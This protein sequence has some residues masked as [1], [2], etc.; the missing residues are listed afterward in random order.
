MNL[1]IGAYFF[2]IA[3]VLAHLEIQI[4]GPHGWAEKLPTWRWDSPA[5]RRWFGKPVT[6]Y[7]LCLVTCILLFLHVPQF[8]GGSWER[9]ADLL[10]M[11][12]LLTVTWDFLWFAC[13]RHF[14]VARFRKGQVW[15][16]PTWA[17]GVPREYFVGIALSFG[18]ALAPA[19]STGAWADRAESWALVVGESLILTLVVTA[20]T[21]G[22]RRRA[23]TR[24]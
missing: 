12:F 11:F 22:P 3:F 4:E 5:I 16:F 7:H 23:S 1:A 14:G 19:L 9:E 13:N 15:W 24:R 17:L 6:G 20:F 10:A 18:A 2:L 8:Y 21:L